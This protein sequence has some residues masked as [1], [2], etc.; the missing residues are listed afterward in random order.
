MRICSWI[1]P[2]LVG[3]TLWAFAGCGTSGPGNNQVAQND[4]HGDKQDESI[5][6]G[7]SQHA[8]T[9]KV[10]TAT[11]SNTEA[12]AA[13]T[14]KAAPAKNSE[15]R[16]AKPADV[17]SE[18][19]YTDGE[20]LK[21]LIAP[22]TP[23][24]LEELSNT[25]WT[26]GKVIDSMK[27]LRELKKTQSKPE[28]DDA[29]L[30]VKN[31]GPAAN[32]RLLATLGRLPVD[33]SEVDW[34]ATINRH[35]K[36]DINSTNPIL[37]STVYEQD[38][39]T[40]T[41][42][43]LF[44]FDWEMNPFA[45][46][47]TVKSWQTSKD[48]TMDKVVMRNDVTWSDGAPVTAH[49]VVFSY[50]VIMNPDVPILA[51]RT[52]VKD[53]K[54]I[55]A[56]DDYTLVFFHKRPLAT[57]VW[58]MNFPVIPKHIYEKT[59]KSDLTLQSSPE[60]V[61]LEDKPVYAGP[62]KIASRTRNVELVLERREEHYMHDGKQVRDKPYFKRVRFRPISDSNTAL[63]ALKTGQ[64]DE[65]ELMPEQ[66]NSQTN[67]DDYYKQCT[68]VTGPES[69]F[70]YFGWNQ[71][72]T[73]FKDRRVRQAMA[74]AFDHKEML[75]KQLYGLYQPANGPYNPG[76]WMYPKKDLPFFERDLDKAERLLREAGWE[77][78]DGDG[79]LDQEIDGKSV[80]FEFTI[81][82]AEIPD[83]VRLCALLKDNLDQIGI[84]CNVRPME[85]ATLFAKMETRDFDAVFA[86]WGAGADPD[87][88]ENIYTTPAI[89]QGRN[90]IAYS[91]RYVDGLFELGKQ[92]PSAKEAREKIVNEYQLGDVGI[93]PDA[94][95]PEVYSKIHELVYEDQPMTFLYY[96]N[97]FYG[98]D[99]S[100]RGYMFSPRGPYHYGPGFSSIWK[101]L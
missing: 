19:T 49:D 97:S 1:A 82:V 2:L 17:A 57:N 98:F 56:Y 30:A 85:I 68:K 22:F 84:V 8:S 63:L 25:E 10:N 11:T 81:L 41:A 61:A 77:D 20:G 26:D 14:D 23:P 65:L 64:L 7:K 51:Q 9:S 76:S 74:Y 72:R 29:V 89:E 60:H 50:R 100:V 91:N 47:D 52:Q 80:R 53:I 88:S 4:R 93:N 3:L 33:D 24:T 70:F 31:D 38:L 75:E 40:L 83:R 58:N 46:S 5:E 86:G 94:T 101:R 78:H 37:A 27:L 95:R 66:W 87:T 39:F 18:K 32:K 54:W 79:V 67:D 42:F 59:W 34:E 99:K 90:Y 48:G 62:Y 96:R 73:L 44:S 55:E 45:T 21:T 35:W 43:G 6:N 16:N 13:T 12:N 28:A 92:M 15:S 69:T 71:A 36:G